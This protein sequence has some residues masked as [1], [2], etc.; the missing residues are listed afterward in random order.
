MFPDQSAPNL[1]QGLNPEQLSAVTW[2]PQ[3]ALVLAGAGS[4]KT[5][6]LTTRIAWLL[7][8]GQASVHSI[9]AALLVNVTAIM[10]CTLA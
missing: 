6:V 3:S 1:L 7:Q 10:L 8:S 9:L 2:P 4:G 5:R